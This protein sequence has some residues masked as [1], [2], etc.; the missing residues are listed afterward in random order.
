MLKLQVGLTVNNVELN[1]WKIYSV[2]LGDSKLL[3]SKLSDSEFRFE[4][5]LKQIRKRIARIF[6]LNVDKVLICDTRT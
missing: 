5:S 4:K 1:Y 6:D 3:L 2:R